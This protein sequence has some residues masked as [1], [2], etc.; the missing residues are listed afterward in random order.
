MSDQPVAE[1]ATYT[2]H[3]KYKSRTFMPS[4]GFEPA[5]ERPQMYVLDSMTT[6][7]GHL[8][9]VTELIFFF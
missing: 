6:G 2:T 1:A 8:D 5:I 4:A 7:I 3:N 9:Y